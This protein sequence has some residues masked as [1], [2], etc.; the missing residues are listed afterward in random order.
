M[1]LATE[2]RRMRWTYTLGRVGETE[3]K[4][5][6]TFLLLV[7]L[8]A[9][10]GYQE[11]G[12]SGA[13]S[14]AATLIA[15]FVCVVLHEFGHIAMARRFG[16]RTPDVLILPIGGVARLERI[17]EEPKQELL[18]ALAGPAVTLAIAVVLYAVLRLTGSPTGTTEVEPTNPILT[19]LF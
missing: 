19:Q 14:A 2:A 16:V 17:P 1:P 5:H 15:L 10:G 12:T 9:A 4:L 3:I 13:I 11:G 6:L 8:W 18:I 7:A